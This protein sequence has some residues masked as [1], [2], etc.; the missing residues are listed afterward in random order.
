MVLFSVLLLLLTVAGLFVFSKRA[1]RPELIFRGYESDATGRRIARLTLTNKFS[2]PIYLMCQRFDDP[3]R[4]AYAV[5]Q[6]NSTGLVNNTFTGTIY[7]VELAAND[8]INFSAILETNLIS[9]LTVETYFT[10]EKDSLTKFFEHF[11]RKFGYQ[12]NRVAS[13]LTINLPENGNVL[14]GSEH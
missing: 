3:S 12:P 6:L 9:G 1:N 10:P 7:S 2:K 8:Q 5:R 14:T 4:V 13:A 11:A